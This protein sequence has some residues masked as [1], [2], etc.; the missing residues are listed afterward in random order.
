MAKRKLVVRIDGQDYSLEVDRL[1]R[2][3]VATLDRTTHYV[4]ELFFGGGLITPLDKR[5]ETVFNKANILCTVD[6]EQ[7][8][9]KIAAALNLLDWIESST[10]GGPEF[11]KVEELDPPY[12]RLPND[13]SYEL[14]K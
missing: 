11:H 1:D 13:S 10:E 6:S 5:G 4:I 9:N 8:A 12:D 3:G 2:Y 7:L 14:K